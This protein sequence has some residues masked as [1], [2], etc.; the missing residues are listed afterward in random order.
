M[1]DNGGIIK[2]ACVYHLEILHVP[3]IEHTLQLGVK[4]CFDVRRVSA[5]LGCCHKSVGFSH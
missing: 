4:K 2:N 5:A 1:T 3:C